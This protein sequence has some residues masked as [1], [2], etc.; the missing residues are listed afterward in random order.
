MP[1]GVSAGSGGGSAASAGG[2]AAPCGGVVPRRGGN[3]AQN[4]G[5]PRQ[6]Q[7]RPRARRGRR[8]RGERCPRQR[9]LRPRALQRRPRR[10]ELRPRHAQRSPAGNG[11]GVPAQKTP[12]LQPISPPGRWNDAPRL[13]HRTPPAMEVGP[14]EHGGPA[15]PLAMARLTENRAG[16]T[17]FRRKRKTGRRTR[18]PPHE[19]VGK[20]SHGMAAIKPPREGV[21]PGKRETCGRVGSAVLLSP[22]NAHQIGRRHFSPIHGPLFLLLLMRKKYKFAI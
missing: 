18:R 2:S 22:C 8:C 19:P 10:T 15:R 14:M 13:P 4:G 17:L 7:R 21:K 20:G 3:G 11:G 5:R 16:P 9:E 1:G 6:C 12:P